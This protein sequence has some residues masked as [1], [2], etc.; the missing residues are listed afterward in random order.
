[1]DQTFVIEILIDKI[2]EYFDELRAFTKDEFTYEITH[3]SSRRTEI[4]EY[5][6]ISVKFQIEP[7]TPV[8]GYTKTFRLIEENKDQFSDSV[9]KL[10]QKF[11]RNYRLQAV[12]IQLTEFKLTVTFVLVNP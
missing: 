8:L 4:N 11:V 12:S 10:I 1:M 5:T 3:A 7:T 9:F 6:E 2:I